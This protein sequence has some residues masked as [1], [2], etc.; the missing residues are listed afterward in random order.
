[1]KKP[2][3]DLGRARGLVV[4][5]VSGSQY[6]GSVSPRPVIRHWAMNELMG[7]GN[8]H[9]ANQ[10][11]DG[12]HVLGCN[13]CEA[14]H[15]ELAILEG[16]VAH[17]DGVDAGAFTLQDLWSLDFVKVPFSHLQLGQMPPLG[18]RSE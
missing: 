2:T 4:M 16:F 10:V 12:S 17:K 5:Q 9:D 18:S 13:C 15:G 14:V 1:M 8:A 3:V 6:L 7:S 11:D